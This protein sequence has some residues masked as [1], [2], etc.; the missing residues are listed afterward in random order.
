MPEPSLL[1]GGVKLDDH[2]RHLLDTFGLRVA[3]LEEA[4]GKVVVDGDVQLYA[5]LLHL[6]VDV[7]LVVGVNGGNLEKGRGSV[8][9]VVDAL[10]DDVQ[11]L[12]TIQIDF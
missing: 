11:L 5:P 3:Y 4:G 1:I 8:E 7:L 12:P 6:R 10:Q 2:L 9:I